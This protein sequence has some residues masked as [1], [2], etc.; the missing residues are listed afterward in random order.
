MHSI[1]PL[2]FVLLVTAPLNQQGSFSALRF[3]EELLATE[4]HLDC[5]FFYWEGVLVGNPLIA[6]PA[7]EFNVNQGW[8]DLAKSKSVKLFLC[9]TEALRRGV[10]AEDKIPIDDTTSPLPGFTCTGLGQLFATIYTCD[11]VIVFS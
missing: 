6:P 9:I 5:V 10:I 11:R 2:H 7:D 8:C 1:K 4:H 3:A